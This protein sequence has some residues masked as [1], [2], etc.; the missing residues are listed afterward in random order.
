MTSTTYSD[1]VY[2]LRVAAT[3]GV[4]A[5]EPGSA[6]A[7]CEAEQLGAG[8]IAQVAAMREQR[9]A[10]IRE[11]IALQVGDR[12]ADTEALELARGGVSDEDLRA[13]DDRF[14]WSPLR[15]VVATAL[16]LAAASALL[17]ATD[18]GRPATGV[19]LVCASV[20]AAIV[21]QLAGRAFGKSADLEPHRRVASL[22]TLALVVVV[23][24]A[25]LARHQPTAAA[26]GLAVA[27]SAFVLGWLA[28]RHDHIVPRQQRVQRVAALHANLAT[29]EGAIASLEARIADENR[30]AS[31]AI[32][33]I[34]AITISACAM[35]CSTVASAAEAD[36]LLSA[37]E[38][39]INAWRLP[40]GA[41]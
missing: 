23:V 16:V 7:V 32:D 25:L 10:S 31:A 21:A 8:K 27:S 19:T 6:Q 14:I 41:L 4:R 22:A 15:A 40:A 2:G 18:R 29:H 33:E 37:A 12:T 11:A 36:R 1:I 9:L 30:A 26:V 20:L 35:R 17:L 28:G 24:C 5:A 39:A 34:R 38:S 3:H 13:Q